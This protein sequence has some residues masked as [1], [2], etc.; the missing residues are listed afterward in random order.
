MFGRAR[1]GSYN[2]RKRGDLEQQF[3]RRRW[4]AISYWCWCAG[5]CVSHGSECVRD[6]E[7]E[8]AR[9]SVEDLTT[10]CNRH[11]CTHTNT[12]TC[13]RVRRHTRIR[14]HMYACIRTHACAHT[15]ACMRTQGHARTHACTHART[16]EPSAQVGSG[17]RTIPL[18]EKMAVRH[19]QT[20]SHTETEKYKSTEIQRYRVITL[21]RHRQRSVLSIREMRLGL[22][23][24][25]S[26]AETAA[27]DRGK[28]GVGIQAHSHL[29]V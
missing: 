9:E 19:R 20:H 14:T 18:R 17:M 6:V 1:L 23:R 12:H 26:L 2:L 27:T 28:A 8:T 7:R 4:R 21:Y 16:S 10:F 3:D 15:Y 5:L 29:T 22:S 24:P 13:T 25:S 11:T